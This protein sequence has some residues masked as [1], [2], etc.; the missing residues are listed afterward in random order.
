MSNNLLKLRITK[1]NLDIVDLNGFKYNLHLAEVQT[2]EDFKVLIPIFDDV[3]VGDV[4]STEDWVITH[5]GEC[6]A[7]PIDLCIRI[8]K[9]DLITGGD[10]TLTKYL[11]SWVY[12]LLLVSERNSLQC[13]GVNRRPFFVATLKIKDEYGNGFPVLL[14]SFG[15]VA[16]KISTMKRGFILKC[17]VTVKRLRQTPGY[18]LSCL[19]AEIVQEGNKK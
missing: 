12:G 2:L 16:K 10:Y 17:E 5:L 14:T 1:T 6:D 3:L 4:V 19:S 8:G 13:V 15:D 9:F 7:N 18:E 11:N